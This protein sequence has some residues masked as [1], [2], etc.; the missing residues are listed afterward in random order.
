MWIVISAAAAFIL[1][2]A[3][4]GWVVLILAAGAFLGLRIGRA[5]GFRQLGAY[6]LADRMRR[7][8][9]KQG[10]WGIF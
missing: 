5:W 8:R 1:I 3:G 6:E 4:L 10:G 9:S 7:A 2:K